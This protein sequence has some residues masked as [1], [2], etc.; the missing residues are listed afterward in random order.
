M[1]LPIGAGVAPLTTPAAETLA[2]PSKAPQCMRSARRG[3]VITRDVQEHLSIICALHL[4]RVM[5]FTH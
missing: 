5:P 3:H 2:C 1:P 4:P